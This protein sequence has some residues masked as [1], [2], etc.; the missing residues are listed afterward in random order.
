MED[1]TGISADEVVTGPRF[2]QIATEF[3]NAILG[4]GQ[5]PDGEDLT[6]IW[7]AIDRP[8]AHRVSVEDMVEGARYNKTSYNGLFAMYRSGGAGSHGAT[9]VATI[10]PVV[11]AGTAL[12]VRLWHMRALPTNAGV[13]VYCFLS[14]ATS[15]L[16]DTLKDEEMEWWT[17]ETP[18]PSDHY[19]TESSPMVW[20]GGR[21]LSVLAGDTI[22]CAVTT[23]NSGYQ[24]G[25][26]I[27]AMEPV[28]E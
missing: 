20:D 25:H 17:N 2:Q 23:I 1:M 21:S 18:T 11:A 5:I 14:I 7:T 13:G 3:K 22:T 12:G 8:S 26:L 19:V 15:R 9:V 28:W 24:G 6:Q 10:G 27:L 16:G 4:T